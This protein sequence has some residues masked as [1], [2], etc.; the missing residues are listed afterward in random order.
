M[1]DRSRSSRPDRRQIVGY[2]PNDRAV[3]RMIDR[4]AT[5]QPAQVHALA[6]AVAWQLACRSRSPCAARL[7]RG[8]RPKRWRPP[9]RGASPGRRATPA[10]AARRGTPLDS[11]GGR[12][13]AGRWCSAENGLR[14]RAVGVI[15]A[16]AFAAQVK[17]P[18]RWRSLRSLALAGAGRSCSCT[19]AARMT[20][21][22]AC[23]PRVEAAAL[24]LVVRDLCSIRET[25]RSARRTVGHRHARLT[26][27]DRHARPGSV[28]R[29]S[30][31]SSPTGSPRSERVRKPGPLE[32][33]DA[34]PTTH[35]LQGRRPAR[36]RR[37]PGLP[38]GPRGHRALP[39][40]GLP[41]ASNHR[42]HTYDYLA[43]DP[44]LGGDER[45]ASC[46]TR[47][48]VAGCG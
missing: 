39:E 18:G 12:S 30:T 13:I 11:P 44:L 31:R 6:G 23:C 3:A 4:A 48:T 42:Y 40:P 8:P 14:R 37:A 27:D 34:P 9:G 41:S 33:W 47:P 5:A 43:V 10:Q 19:R 28:T 24:A 35:G 45:C 15:G 25:I 2:G 20:R 38:R 21:V 17:R 32:P 16:I 29:S 46:S 26:R 22:P 1:A 36:H 7:R